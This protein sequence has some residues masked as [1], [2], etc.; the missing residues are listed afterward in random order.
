MATP[1]NSLFSPTYLPNK[2]LHREQ[3][4]ELLT[5]FLSI[6][7]SSIQPVNVMVH[8]SFGIGRTTLLRFLTHKELA[9]CKRP[10]ISFYKKSET[11]IMQD[12]FS[13]LTGSGKRTNLLPEQWTGVKRVL[14]KTKTPHIFIFDDVDRHNVRIY[15]KFLRLCKENRIPSLTTAP[16][17]FPRQLDLETSQN[18]DYAMELEPYSDNQFLDIITQRVKTAFPIPLAR[19]ITE[20]IADII[21]LLDYQRPA[22]A[23]ELLR[24]LFPKIIESIELSADHVRK[25][26]LSIKTLHYDFWTGHLASLTNL[27][28]SSILLIQ[29]VGEYF[30]NDENNI[31]ISTPYL[32]YQYRQVCERSGFR[33]TSPQFSRSLSALLFHDLLLQSRYSSENYFTLISGREYLEIVDLLLG[34]AEER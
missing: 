24:N 11:E 7:D 29:A 26:C 19:T 25:S 34:D 30:T 14:R 10:F 4:L 27:D 6:D 12:I 21:C 23:I 18:L 17:Y 28:V 20:F 2:L 15:D 5:A 9:F 1:P 3:E 8:G 22:T 13:I 33:P 32:F 31:Y 16:R